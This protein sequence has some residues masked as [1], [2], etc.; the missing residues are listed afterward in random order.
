M[1][2]GA[3]LFCNSEQMKLRKILDGRYW[4][5]IL[6]NFPVNKGHALIVLKR[7]HPDI[8]LLSWPEWKD[9]QDILEQAKIYLDFEY[10]S[11]GYNIGVNSGEAAS[12]TI[13]HLHIHLIPRYSG[14]TENPRGD[15]RN[16]KKPV[17]YD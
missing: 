6:D 15:I 10:H 2:S 4:F 17:A 8:F 9:L 7:H 1:E 11:D 3:C 13:F 5:M 16:F 12:Q 14:D